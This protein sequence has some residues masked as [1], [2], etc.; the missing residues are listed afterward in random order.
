M[1]QTRLVK[2]LALWVLNSISL[3]VLSQI[4]SSSIVLGNAVLSRGLASVFS[5]FLMTIIFFL[6]PASAEKA[7]IKV[8]DGR[9]WIV[10]DFVAL[11]IGIWIVKRLSVLTGLGISNILFVILVAALVTI[12]DFGVDKYSDKLL[13]KSK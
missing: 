5:A 7:E 4:F 9:L 13:K 6:V 1:E 8:K 11:V 10:L 2:F 12:L 3:A